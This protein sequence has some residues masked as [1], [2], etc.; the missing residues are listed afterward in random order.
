MNK[1]TNFT[2][3][4][5]PLSFAIALILGIYI[6]LLPNIDSLYKLLT[7]CSTCIL[8]L[9]LFSRPTMP[10]SIQ[11]IVNLFMLVFFILANAVQYSHK[12]VISSLD[13]SF[14]DANYIVFQLLVLIIILGYNVIYKYFPTQ[15]HISNRVNFR[16][17]SPYTI[18][19]L[20][21][22]SFGCVLFYFR[23]N[24][25]N[26]FFRGVV[27]ELVQYSQ[28]NI[29]ISQSE[30]LIFD[31]FIRI[32]PAV[33]YYLSALENYNRKMRII[34][35][36]IFLLS[37]FPLAIPRN[38]V[39]LLWLPVLFINIR[40]MYRP[41]IFILIMIFG[42]VVV[43]PFLDV[44]R[45]FNGEIDFKLQLDYF[46]SMHFD[47]SQNFMALLKFKI[48]TYGKQLLG[49]LLF[50][51][52]RSIWPTKP[53]GSGAFLADKQG[54]FT[55]ISMPFFAEGYINLGFWGVVLFVIFFAVFSA[56]MD[57]RFWTSRNNSN[58]SRSKI[59]YFLLIGASFFIMRGDLMSS[60]AY[61]V[62]T[63]ITVYFVFYVSRLF[64]NYAET[65]SN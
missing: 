41:N 65:P 62:G 11:K 20:S 42:L 15:S 18:L 3:R 9:L 55:N 25:L 59:T 40:L 48:V 17:P 16:K 61:T 58:D 57:K 53:V 8:C 35:F 49:V 4:I 47:A 38:S 63:L 27:E 51:V 56:Y 50:F 10:F 22:L 24:W 7:I 34:T 23:G 46:N 19:F 12:N 60:F 6:I 21:L 36:L 33:C 54:V 44:F 26:M 32:I 39:A 30:S 45:R 2:N 14:S 5:S 1:H 64:T 29:E 52:P 28:D 37:D 13:V 31:H 43:F